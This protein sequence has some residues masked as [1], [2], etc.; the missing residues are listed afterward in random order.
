VAP[1]TA[2]TVTQPFLRVTFDRAAVNVVPVF[3]QDTLLLPRRARLRQQDSHNV[4]VPFLTLHV[5]Y[6]LEYA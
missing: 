4:P 5:A 1:D 3:Q 2:V 6:L